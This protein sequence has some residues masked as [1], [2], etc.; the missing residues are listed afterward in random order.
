[1][2]MGEVHRSLSKPAFVKALQKLI[3]QI[4]SS[5]LVTGRAGVRAQAVTQDGN[6]FD[7]FLI[8]KSERAIHVLNAPSPAATSA[9]AIADQIVAKM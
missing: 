6:L 8:E 2:G 5:D 7:D 1:M 9:L 3:P 4:K